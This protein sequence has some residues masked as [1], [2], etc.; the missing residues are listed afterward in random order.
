MNPVYRYSIKKFAKKCKTSNVDGLIIVDG[1]NNSPEDKELSKELKKINVAYVK[2][3]A[4][5]ND[6]AFTSIGTLDSNTGAWV[7][8]VKSLTG[9]NNIFTVQVKL[10]GTFEPDFALD[11]IS[12]VFREKTVK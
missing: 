4:P 9:A 2:L 8:E 5:T 10:T 7:R 6:G 11:D 1:N 3:V 12:I